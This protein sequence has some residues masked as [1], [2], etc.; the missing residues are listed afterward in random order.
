MLTRFFFFMLF[1][2]N[3]FIFHFRKKENCDILDLESPDKFRIPSLHN[4]NMLLKSPLEIL[5]WWTYHFPSRIRG[6]YWRVPKFG[7]SDPQKNKWCLYRDRQ[8]C[9]LCRSSK[10]RVSCKP[11]HCS[12]ILPYPVLEVQQYKIVYLEKDTNW[13]KDTKWKIEKTQMKEAK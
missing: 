8:E 10:A 2:I 1:S 9:H 3:G 11:K 6:R 7:Y 12:N 5:F 4:F 13:S